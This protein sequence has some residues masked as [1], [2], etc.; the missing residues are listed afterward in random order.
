MGTFLL[1]W[2]RGQPILTAPN[3]IGNRSMAK[4]K[5]IA[6]E[7]TWLNPNDKR[8]VAA[9]SWSVEV[10]YNADKQK[11]SLKAEIFINEEGQTHFISRRAD[12]KPIRTMTRT[13][14]QFEQAIDEAL[15]WI[16]AQGY[17]LVKSYTLDFEEEE[18]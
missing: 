2:V 11:A 17:E 12:L 5:I 4:Q 16:H 7:R 13:L 14:N 10:W 6:N 3:T 1:Y 9:A 15:M 18:I 8:C